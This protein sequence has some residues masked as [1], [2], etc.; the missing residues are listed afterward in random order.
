M[1]SAGPHGRRRLSSSDSERGYPPSI[2]TPA[3]RA[4]AQQWL[5]RRFAVEV[6][7][8][9]I[10]ACVGTK[11]LVGTLPQF[12]RLRSPERDTVLYPAVSYPTYAMGAILAGCRAVPVPTD[13][14]FR[15]RLDAIE[16]DDA[17]R[18]LV[19]WVNSPGNPTGAVE[20]IEAAAAAWG[21]AAG[22]RLQRRVL[23]RVHLGRSTPH[24]P[25]TRVGWRGRG[26]T[27]SPSG[28]TWLGS[29]VGFYAGDA[30][31]VDYLKEVRKHVGLLVPGPAQAAGVVASS[32]TT[33]WV[34]AQRDRYRAAWISWPERSPA[35]VESRSFPLLV[36]STSGAMLVTD[37]VSL[38]VWREGGALLSPGEFY[39]PR[40][41]H[42]VRVAVVQPLDRLNLVVERL[43]VS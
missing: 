17:A 1:R 21:R 24:H 12:L 14:A 20:E 27:R 37:G 29:G 22:A 18:A 28:R 2:G 11:E 31:L 36:G 13:A 43:G 41:D 10:A 6:P 9:Q 38:N 19:L 23:L 15:L 26:R 5:G 34:S 7:T 35:G 16:P 30:E 25:R 3:L 4:A 8:S 39:G 40:G 33:L 42:H 32:T